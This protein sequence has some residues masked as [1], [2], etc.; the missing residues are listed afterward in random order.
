MA[1]LPEE[2]AHHDEAMD[3][4]RRLMLHIADVCDWLDEVEQLGMPRFGELG[5]RLQPLRDDL[6]AHFA[7]EERDGYLAV[8]LAKVP[9][10]RGEAEEL[11][12]Q[13]SD[14]LRDLESL[15]EHLRET[16]SPFR[17]WQDARRKFE[18][19]VAALRQHEQREAAIHRAAFEQSDEP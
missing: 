5:N 11:C 10:F 16:E 7:Q 1:G 9:R 15:S 14:F 18:Q 3:E 6:I 17:T 4:H 19:L 2:Q 8:P 12:R 13:H